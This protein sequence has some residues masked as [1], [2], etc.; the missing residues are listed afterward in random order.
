MTALVLVVHAGATCMMAGLIWFVQV[1]HYPLFDRVGVAGFAAY[2]Q[3]HAART[4]L[5]VGPLMVVELLT[6]VWLALAPELSPNVD[7]GA[8]PFFR[9]VGVA[10]VGVIWLSTFAWQVPLHGVLASGFDG[11]AHARLVASNWLRTAAWSARAGLA[12]WLLRAG[13]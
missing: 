10:L 13:A 9:W 1:V 3:A 4:T 8:G 11:D 12:L 2:E 6:A 7:N 5:V